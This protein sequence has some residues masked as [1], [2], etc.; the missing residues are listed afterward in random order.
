MVGTR[1]QLLVTS[2]QCSFFRMGLYFSACLF[3]LPFCSHSL[4]LF[5]FL[6][7][8]SCDCKCSFVMLGILYIYIHNFFLCLS[9]PSCSIYTILLVISRFK[10]AH[11]N[12]NLLL[13]F[14]H[15]VQ[16]NTKQHLHWLICGEWLNIHVCVCVRE[17]RQNTHI[18]CVSFGLRYFAVSAVQW[19]NDFLFVWLLTFYLK[20]HSSSLFS[21]RCT[22]KRTKKI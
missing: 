13:S 6:L 17:F 16:W 3:Y 20:L 9:Y 10:V 7:Y 19:E 4:S 8:L 2:L 12:R 5:L 1:L 21:F 14:V 18:C 15:W 22:D 11:G